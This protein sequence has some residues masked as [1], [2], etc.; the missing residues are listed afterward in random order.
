MWFFQRL[1]LLRKKGRGQEV[2]RKLGAGKSKKALLHNLGGKRKA[3][4]QFNETS[5]GGRSKQARRVR[6]FHT[7]DKAA[8]Q[9]KH[10]PLPQEKYRPVG[11]PRAAALTVEPPAT[12]FLDQKE[13]ERR[14]EGERNER[15]T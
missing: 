6:G 5:G 15:L 4:K 9:Q 11:S 3:S 7:G 13:R 1:D 12:L 2:N 14:T 8:R 10:H